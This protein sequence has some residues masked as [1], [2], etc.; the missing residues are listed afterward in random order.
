VREKGTLLIKAITGQV[1]VEASRVVVA[2]EM[3]ARV[4]DNMEVEAAVITQG[5]LSVE[6]VA[7][8]QDMAM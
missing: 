5:L 4:T 3:V 2:V 7:P 1:A 8:I 6:Q